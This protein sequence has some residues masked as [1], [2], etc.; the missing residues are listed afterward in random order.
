M[1]FYQIE[2]PIIIERTSKSGK[3]YLNQCLTLKNKQTN[4]KTM[5]HISSM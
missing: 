3:P 1:N 5:T 2:A 4:N